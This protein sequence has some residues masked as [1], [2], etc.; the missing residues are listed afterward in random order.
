MHLREKEAGREISDEKQRE[1][2]RKKKL[3]S[4][5]ADCV[6]VC[7]AVERTSILCVPAII[8]PFEG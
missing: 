4:I 1:R 3:S 8:S 2:E 7:V 6:L 5:V